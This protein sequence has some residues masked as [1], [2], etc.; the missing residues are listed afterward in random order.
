MR[1]DMSM[2]L[3]V[4]F[5]SLGTEITKENCVEMCCMAAKNKLIF[6]YAASNPGIHHIRNDTTM[7][8][9][10]TRGYTFFHPFYYNASKVIA[11]YDE[12]T[13]GNPEYVQAIFATLDEVYTKI[14][15]LL[16]ESGIP[17]L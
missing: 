4:L 9:C 10:Y 13:L 1:T 8:Y 2:P 15:A 11:M 16:K 6:Q 3:H 17:T 5:R 14:Q 7:M 12:S